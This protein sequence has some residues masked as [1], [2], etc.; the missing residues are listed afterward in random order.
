MFERFVLRKHPTYTRDVACA[1][2]R[3]TASC[4]GASGPSKGA[5]QACD[6]APRFT[7]RRSITVVM[8][9]RSGGKQVVGENYRDAA[10][11][12]ASASRVPGV[13]AMLTGRP[14]VLPRTTANRSRMARNVVRDVRHG[15]F[16]NISE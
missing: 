12:A 6:C 11:K 8:W 15:E 13:R 14:P 2:R 1:D 3:A 10:M 4:A 16:Q 7:M 9:G 5:D